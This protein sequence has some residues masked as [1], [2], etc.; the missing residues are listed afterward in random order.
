MDSHIA[1]S[2]PRLHAITR[3]PVP[4]GATVGMF[5]GFDGTQL[6]FAIWQPSQRPRR[7]TVCLFSGRTECI[8]KYF[9][10]VADLRRRGFAVATMDWRGQGGSQRLLSNA[11]KGHV[12]NFAD[13]DRDLIRFMRDVVL[14]DCPPP[15]YA[16]AH[17]MGGNILLRAATDPGSWFER[18]ILCAPMVD[19]HPGGLPFPPGVVRSAM[20]AASLLGMGRL[21]PP[22]QGD[23]SWQDT[24]FEDNVLTSS[25]E[26]YAR[27]EAI[28]EEAPDLR[29]AAPTVGWLQAAFRS[30]AKVTSDRFIGSV[31]VPL[32]L[33]AAGDDKVV[34]STAIED[35]SVQLKVGAHI[36]I[37]HARHEIL[38]ERD[39][40]RQQFWAAFDAY[41]GVNSDI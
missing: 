21:Y 33:I 29:I 32:L 4:S 36:V 25:Q 3:N 34:S 40:I 2:V 31:R 26:R 16:L 5:P 8:E 17:S 30:M 28:L 11:R 9:E 7:G 10:V 35:L 23:S 22:G 39:E 18:M 27:N 24:P 6:R 37:P 12:A 1:G 15:Y 14:P 41:V 38:Q 20:A 13:Y 19:L